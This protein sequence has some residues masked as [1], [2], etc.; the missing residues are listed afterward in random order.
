MKLKFL[1]PRTRLILGL[2]TLLLVICTSNLKLLCGEA[3]LL[4][5]GIFALGMSGSWLKSLKISAP[6]VGMVFLVGLISFPFLEAL[7]MVIRF[8]ALLLASFLLFGSLTAAELEGALRRMGVP[9]G[10][11][12]MLVTAMRY[13]PLMGRRLR[14]TVEAQRS[15]GIDL[16]PRIENIKNL[17]ALLAPLLIQ[18][19]Q[20]A[21]DLAMAMEARGFSRKGRT[22]TGKWR[23]RVW[24]YGLMMLWG[25]TLA[26]LIGTT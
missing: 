22:L 21:E 4:L 12:F 1:D 11:C 6:M 9:Y 23:I 16:R 24:E 2:L 15:R 7:E 18:S 13:V 3:A 10:F 26:L 25:C 8:Q 14:A 19:F 20:L 17:A 5:L